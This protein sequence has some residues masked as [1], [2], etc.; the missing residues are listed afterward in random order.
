MRTVLTTG[1]LTLA[2]LAGLGWYLSPLEPGVVA[3]QFAHTPA[4]FN[5]VISQWSTADLLR[6]R[7][8]LPVDFLLLAAY[9]SFGY[10]LVSRAQVLHSCGPSLRRLATWCLPF[11]ALCDAAENVL[12]WW[13]TDVPRPDW[14]F[15]YTAS[16]G[17]SI[18]KWGLIVGFTLLVVHA[19]AR[20]WV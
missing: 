4:A 8:H 6:F 5:E 11:A 7:R 1:L 3:L 16:A 9:G 13:L 18:S 2:L 15:V 17:F 10:L 19:R 12:H 20:T 14:P